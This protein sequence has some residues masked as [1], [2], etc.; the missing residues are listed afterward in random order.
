[1]EGQGWWD[2]LEM[3]EGDRFVDVDYD[4]YLVLIIEICDSSFVE[5]LRD[6]R[7]GFS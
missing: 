1:M 5:E 6:F 3:C 7:I 2:W 4:L